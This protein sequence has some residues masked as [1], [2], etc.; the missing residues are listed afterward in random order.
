MY[1]KARKYGGTITKVA[2][3]QFHSKLEASVH[4]MLTLR[5]KAKELT[6][7]KCQDVQY[8][9]RARIRYEPDFKC[10]DLVTLEE[11]W[12]E[13]KG[14]A[15]DRW[16]T[17]KK[18]WGSYGPGKLEIWTGTYKYPTLAEIIIPKTKPCLGCGE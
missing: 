14:Y 15:N 12:V 1:N 18:L 13:A 6:V 7:L 2:G 17:I 3:L 4:Q 5:E 8:L 10:L 9:T 16:P 11:F